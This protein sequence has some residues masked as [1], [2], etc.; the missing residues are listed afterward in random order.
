MGCFVAA[1]EVVRDQ[2]GTESLDHQVVVVQGCDDSS[3]RSAGNGS[4]DVRGRH[5][6]SSGVSFRL[7]LCIDKDV[8][9]RLDRSMSGRIA[10][11]ADVADAHADL[12]LTLYT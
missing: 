12:H 2:R 3:R 11:L 7:M 4:G 1:Y 9:R 5:A 8:E 6:E 10:L